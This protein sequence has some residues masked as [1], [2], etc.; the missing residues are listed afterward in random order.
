MLRFLMKSFEAF[1]D[2]FVIYEQTKQTQD[3][4]PLFSPP[5]THT[6]THTHK[7]V[8]SINQSDVVFVSGWACACVCE[9][10]SLV[11]IIASKFLAQKLTGL[12]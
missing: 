4:T 1:A 10:S 11:T 5:H 6:H 8:T 12:G 2:S 7:Q 3:E 9:S